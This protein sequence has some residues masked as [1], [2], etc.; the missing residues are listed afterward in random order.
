MLPDISP[1][2][3][4]L[5]VTKYRKV[6]KQLITLCMNS[7]YETM[8]ASLMYYGNFCNMLKLNQF[9][10]NPYYPY[11]VNRLVNGLQKSILFYIDDSKLIH[12]YP[13][14]NDSFIGVLREEYQSIFEDGSGTTQ[15]KL[16]KVH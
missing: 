11:V 3:Y 6:I 7:I 8:V 1:Y 10:M 4:E 2:V 9:K 12:K 13:K 16:G 15:V 5:Y 14:V